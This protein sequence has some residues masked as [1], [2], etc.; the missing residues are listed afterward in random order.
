MGPYLLNFSGYKHASYMSIRTLPQSEE[1][2]TTTCH[3]TYDRSHRSPSC[4]PDKWHGR[5]YVLK[6][7]KRL[8]SLSVRSRHTQTPQS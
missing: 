8:P 3:C 7:K 6:D 1:E 4:A 5:I 2:G